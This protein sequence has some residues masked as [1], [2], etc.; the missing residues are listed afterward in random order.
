MLRGFG[1]GAIDPSER[2][3]ED[4]KPS[5]AGE[6]GILRSPEPAEALLRVASHQQFIAI[7]HRLFEMLIT[8]PC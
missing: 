1:K 7:R 4:A 6:F 8:G 5:K 2:R 3:T